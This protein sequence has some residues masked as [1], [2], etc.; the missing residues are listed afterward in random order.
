MKQPG[1]DASGSSKLQEVGLRFGGS[2]ALRNPGKA[3]RR[4]AGQVRI[5]GGVT[6]NRE[7]IWHSPNSWWN[8]LSSDRGLYIVLYMDAV[9]L[10][11]TLNIALEMYRALL[12]M[13]ALSALLNNSLSGPQ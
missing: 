13:S 12:Y 5:V 6:R 2:C 4:C 9:L 11:G 3:E 1:R 8:T 10:L 7:A